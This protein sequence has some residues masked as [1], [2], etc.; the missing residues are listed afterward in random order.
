MKHGRTS[1]CA[2]WKTGTPVISAGSRLKSLAVCCQFKNPECLEW[3]V[4]GSLNSQAQPLSN[5]LIAG[6]DLRDGDE[7]KGMSNR[8][9]VT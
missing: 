9:S 2:F 3:S 5:T 6:S 7:V 1:L 8:V 4:S